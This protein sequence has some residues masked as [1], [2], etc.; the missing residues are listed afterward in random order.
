MNIY[1]LRPKEPAVLWDNP[2]DKAF[3]HVVRAQSAIAARELAM[4][5]C[6]DETA[7]AW[8]VGHST[9]ELIALGVDGVAK[10]IMTDFNSG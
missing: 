10:V 4:K 5:E 2:Y 6:G 7:R 3:G 9:C 8:S 1:L